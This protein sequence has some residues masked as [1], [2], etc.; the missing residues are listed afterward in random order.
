MFDFSIVTKWFDELLRVTCGLSNF[1]A[2]LIE[3][4]VVGLAILLAYALLAIV[5]IFMER[6]VCAYFQC[7]IGPVR[8]GWWGTL[9]VLADVLKM[10]IKE[11]FA[12]DKADKLLYYLAPFLVIIASVGTFSFLPWN[13]GA[14]ILDFNVG[15]FLVTA[16]SSIGVVG[17][18]I[19]GWGSNNKYSVLSAMR[20]AVQMIS[21]ELSLGVCLISAVYPNT[22]N[23]DFRYSRSA[24]RSLA[25]VDSTRTYPS[26]LGFPC[27]LY[28]G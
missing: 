15:I 24:D 27:I 18:F 21:Y 1:W 5:L 13:K 10:L 28:C 8:V 16:I 22:N 14:H 20:G 26:Y 23:A 2:V 4:V 12:V 11:I 19:A 17:V 25:V 7:R 6:K 9:Q 3:C